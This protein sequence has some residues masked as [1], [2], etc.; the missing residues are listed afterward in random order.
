M[1]NQ[2]SPDVSSERGPQSVPQN[3]KAAAIDKFGG[4]EAIHT[5]SVPV[6]HP[7]PNEVL[8]Q[9]ETAGV[10]QWDPALINGEFSDGHKGFPQIHGSDGAGTI[11]A[12]GKNV[13]RLKEGDRVYGYGFGNAKG[14]FYAEYT[15]VPEENVAKIPQGLSVEEA[16]ALAVSGLTALEGLESLDLKEGSTLMIIG[17][18]GGV[19]HV[20]LQ[21]AKRMGARVFAV[22]SGKD[23]VD[24]VRRLGADDA[25][26]GK[27]HDVA[28]AAGKYLKEGFDAALVF[29]GRSDGWKSVLALVKKGGTVAYPNGVEPPPV[30]RKGVQLKAYDGVS[31]PDVYERLNNLIEKGA[32]HV[33]LGHLYPLDEASRAIADVGGHHIGKLAIKIH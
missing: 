20:A 3:M 14:G 29:A 1:A 19:G 9:V 16:G 30:T 12:V 7:A 28:Q 21:L 5:A 27:K 32:F 6:P 10:G 17:A 11:V 24:L 4:P 25:V 23:G 2:Q 33:E 15:S 13:K 31:A 26:E 18:S 22:A 8:I